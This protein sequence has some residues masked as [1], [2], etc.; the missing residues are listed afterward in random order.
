[1]TDWTF[2][3]GRYEHRTSGEWTYTYDRP[4]DGFGPQQV[5]AADGSVVV[6]V[7]RDSAEGDANGKLIADAPRLLSALVEARAEVE[8]LRGLIVELVA[9]DTNP[10]DTRWEQLWIEARKIAEG[11]NRD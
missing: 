4:C 8:R 1:M 11:V 6:D 5:V 10:D 9:E 7:P 3:E 2:D